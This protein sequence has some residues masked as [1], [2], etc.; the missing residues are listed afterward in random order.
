MK[1]YILAILITAIICITGTVI[2]SNYLASE[3]AY[4]DTT[5]ENALNDLYS[6]VKP[7]YDGELSFTPSESEQTIT[8]AN[9][10]LTSNITI[11][12]IPNEYKKL[13]T[14]TD[15]ESNKLLNGVKAYNSNGELITG[16]ISTNCVYGTYNH[17]KNT[18][19]NINVGFAATYALLS[20][21]KS[22]DLYHIVYNGTNF[23]QNRS[24]QNDFS[25][26]NTMSIESNSIKSSD[27][28]TS[29][30]YTDAYTVKYMACK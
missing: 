28:T 30:K 22:N 6:K 11:G 5:V 29:T 16:T 9:K 18:Q 10:L 1:K 19:I 12:A 25:L 17:A 2:A 26:M 8:T 4:K 24:S 7:E 13:T 21:T 15:V 23:Y 3:I 27:P 20:F 14:E